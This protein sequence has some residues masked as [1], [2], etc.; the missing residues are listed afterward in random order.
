MTTSYNGWTAGSRADARII[1]KAVPGTKVGL[2]LNADAAPV[3]LWV[4][5]QFHKRVEPL[6]AG[7]CWGWADRMVRGSTT[8]I[9]NHASG[10]AMDLNAPNHP[11]GHRGTFTDKQVGQIRAILREAG[12]VTWGGNYTQRVDEMHFE[13]SD[14]ATAAE[15]R[16]AGARLNDTRRRPVLWR[17][18]PKHP[19]WT[20]V[21]QRQLGI[22]VDGVFG[23]HMK[24]AVIAFRRRHKIRPYVG[25][26]GPRVWRAL[27][28]K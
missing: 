12:V 18:G 4:A 20:R 2:P 23:R 26:I 16:A 15:V 14:G 6:H 3:L 19:H 22:R 25:V 10:T 24:A 8:K 11:L 27:L 13:I 1:V 21:A 28:A 17:T 5:E 9:S 7:W